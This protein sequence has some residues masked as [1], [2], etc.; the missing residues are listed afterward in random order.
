MDQTV[1]I[2]GSRRL[3]RRLRDVMAEGGTAQE[4]LDRIVQIV[5]SDMVAEVCSA[6]VMR[7]GDILE[8]FATEGLKR[9]A[10]HRTRLRLGEG[11]V[12]V[13]AATANPLALADAQSHP[14]FAY[15]PET[16]EEIYH[17]LMGVP[18]LRAGRVTGVLVVQNRSLRSYTDEEIE[19][20]QTI[21]MVVA[22]LV[23]GGELVAA[24]ELHYLDGGNALL[25]HRLEGIRL[26]AGLGV[27]IAVPH[28]PNIVIRQVI[29]DNPEVELLRLGRAV[30]DMQRAVDALLQATD[31]ADGSESRDILE[32]Y[33]MF[34]E[35]RGWLTRIREAVRGGLTAEAAV[36]KVRDDTRAR[37]NQISDPYIRERLLDLEDLANRLQH[38][39][40]GERQTA[41]SD[42]LPDDVVLVARNMGPAELL[43]YDRKRLRALVLEEGSPTSHVTV[44]ARALDIP[45]VGRAKGALAQIEAGDMV[46]VD[47]DN[48]Q[49]L[50]RPGEDVQLAVETR[51]ADRQR[52]QAEYAE[53]RTLP[54]LTRDGIAISLQLNAGLLFDMNELEP[55]AADGIGLYRTEIPF[56]VRSDFPD[57]EQQ[58]AFYR[59][60]LDQAGDRPVTFRTLDIGGDKVLPYLPERI[61]ENPAMGWRAVRVALDRPAMLRQQ[62]RA[63]I[64]A[65]GGRRLRVMFPMVAEVAEFVSLKAILTLELER[66]RQRGVVL[67][68]VIEVGAMLEVPSLVWQLPTL[69]RVV[70]FISVGSNDLTQFL[71]ASDRGNARLAE[72]YDV[73]SPP[74]L[75]CLGQIART[76]GAAGVPFSMCGEM[77]GRPLEAMVLAGLGYRSLSMSPSS[78]GPVKSM[79]RR[80]EVGPLADYL[81]DLID[82]PD[83]SLRSKLSDFARDRGVQL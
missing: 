31:I 64:R 61:E 41:A 1:G 33:R 47:G 4:R 36:Q 50:I 39:L 67:P 38:H 62:L 48:A 81:A 2:T 79:V 58:A 25:P 18:I 63:M 59:K 15:R 20:L 54:A 40:S 82:R 57:V 37:M 49:V 35:D 13:V 9:E 19:T 16:G 29:A 73:L 55:T 28:A 42:D 65:A 60:V 27:G 5:A 22:E 80:L 8:L 75:K 76:A 45:V 32:A 69:C 74:M 7:A 14:S 23:A 44:V 78:I 77:A 26:N 71:F 70:D 10:V 51:L 52:Q 30:V 43:D 34:A 17:S 83:H 12:G 68:S 72:R 46:V 3:L 53:L 21:A 66:G 24:G 6:Y 11:L 56:M